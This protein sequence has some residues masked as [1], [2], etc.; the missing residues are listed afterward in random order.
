MPLVYNRMHDSWKNLIWLIFE[1]N[2]AGDDF[3][4]QSE[5]DTSKCPSLIFKNKK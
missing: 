4:K 1:N 5:L 2:D 3:W